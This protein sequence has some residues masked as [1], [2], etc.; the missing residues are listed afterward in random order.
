METAIN[1]HLH[2]YVFYELTEPVNTLC[3][4]CHCETAAYSWSERT[5]QANPKP[6]AIVCR[7]CAGMILLIGES[8]QLHWSQE[9]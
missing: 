1:T 8:N 5:N 2:E 7:V 4:I 6:K 9:S 3:E